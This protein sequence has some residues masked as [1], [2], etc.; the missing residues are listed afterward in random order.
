MKKAA[1]GAY[2]INSFTRPKEKITGAD[3]ELWF[4]GPSGKWLG[5]RVQAKVI[6]IDGKRYAQLHYKRKDGTSQ[7]DQL[8]ADAK[9]HGAVPLHCL[10]SYWKVTDL[11]KPNWPCGGF[12]KNCRL[13]GAS[14]MAA[15]HVQVLKPKGIDSL[16]LVA[17]YLR[18]F[19]C[20]FCSHGYVEGDLPTRAISFLRAAG[21]LTDEV[22]ELRNEPPYYV[23]Q[24]LRQIPVWKTSST[25]GMRICTGSQSSGS[26]IENRTCR[27]T[28]TLRDKAAHRRSPL[29]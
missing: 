14:W 9:R 23:A 11:G 2:Y 7:V 20:L 22:F 21:H 18:P 26:T 5:L 1:K 17:K 8:V 3:W 15:K 10:Y 29:R 28:W 4:S 24:M 25:F 16:N 12:K 19:H 6:A 27:S 13:F